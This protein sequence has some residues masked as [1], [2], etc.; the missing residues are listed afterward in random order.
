VRLASQHLKT[1]TPIMAEAVRHH[2]AEVVGAVYDLKTGKVQL[3]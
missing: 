1:A 3:V 2:D